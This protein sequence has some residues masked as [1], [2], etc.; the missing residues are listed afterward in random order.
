MKTNNIESG[1]YEGYVW[2]N[3]ANEPKTIKGN[4]EEDLSV[5]NPFIVEGFLYDEEKHLS[6]SIKFVDGAY[7][8]NRYEVTSADMVST[9]V[10]KKSFYAHRMI[11]HKKLDF[12]EYWRPEEDDLC[13]GM[14]VLQPAE[15]V[16]VGFNDKED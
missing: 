2:Y 10:K 12:L 3:D 15:L 6:Y 16:F 5:K 13:C 11:G 8:I 1:N 9:E 7:L 14:K 4:F